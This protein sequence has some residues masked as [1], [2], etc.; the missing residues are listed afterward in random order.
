MTILQFAQEIQSRFGN[1]G[2]IDFKSLPSDDPKVRQPDISK[3]Y[4]VLGWQPLVSLDEGLSITID[5]FREKV[6]VAN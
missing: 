1:S 2:K 5:Y 4:S 3:A 6:A